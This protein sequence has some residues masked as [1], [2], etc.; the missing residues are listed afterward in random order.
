M[1][2]FFAIGFQRE[3]S[4]PINDYIE[5]TRVNY[6]LVFLLINSRTERTKRAER[7]EMISFRSRERSK[8]FIKY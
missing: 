2:V 8:V 3:L 6:I 4:G 1:T 7:V 5:V